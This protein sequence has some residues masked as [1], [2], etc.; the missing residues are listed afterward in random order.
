VTTRPPRTASKAEIRLSD[1][2]K[3]QVDQAYIERGNI[4]YAARAANVAYKMAHFWVKSHI[5]DLV[6]ARKEKREDFLAAFNLVRRLALEELSDPVRIKKASTHDLVVIVGVMTDKV[7]LL[8]GAP[9]SHV[10]VDSNIRP[11][12]LT[13]EDRER[14]RQLREKMLDDGATK[15]MTHIIDAESVVVR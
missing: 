12:A 7:N 15:R 13:P 5:E 6:A 3:A 4:A 2:E 10:R 14:A 8:Q 11:E 9:T 1:W